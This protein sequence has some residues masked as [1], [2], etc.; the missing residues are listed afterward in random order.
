[1]EGVVKLPYFQPSDAFGP[2]KVKAPANGQNGRILNESL[3]INR[4]AVKRMSLS[5]AWRE[6][7]QNL[8]DAIVEANGDSFVGIRMTREQRP[9][10]VTATVF[11]T[12]EFILGEIVENKNSIC[13]VNMA[14]NIGSV[15]QLIHIGASEKEALNNQAGQ[16]GEGLKRAA[17][18]FIDAGYRMKLTFPLYVEGQTEIRKL[19]FQFSEKHGCLAYSLTPVAPKDR[20]KNDKHRFEL[21]IETGDQVPV[22]DVFDFLINEPELIRD[23]LDPSDSG[24]LVLSA[25][26]KGQVY[27]WHFYVVTYKNMVFGYV[28]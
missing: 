1:M 17:M 27:V 4:R 5:N 24:S 6:V 2:I 10:N 28:F 26:K 9:R 13:F 7:L 22:F 25:D 8:V 12:D 15:E 14:P 18:K 11:H 3:N 21:T 23:V 16:H 20:V 19:K